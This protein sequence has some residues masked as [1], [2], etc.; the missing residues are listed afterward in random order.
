MISSSKK[1]PK[2]N[3]VEPVTKSS[4]LEDE[5][6]KVMQPRTQKGPAW[7]DDVALDGSKVASSSKI[8]D[9]IASSSKKGKE[10]ARAPLVGE[11]E[12]NV[13]DDDAMDEDKKDDGID[14]MEWMKRHMSKG[15][16]LEDEPTKEFY[17]DDDGGGYGAKVCL[18]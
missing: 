4:A 1:N 7:L 17:Q 15:M 11:N 18:D 3:N 10:R 16:Q 6:I 5:F 12:T 8:T 14:D 9:G 13:D 2:D